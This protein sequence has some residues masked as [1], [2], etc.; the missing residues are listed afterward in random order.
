[1]IL[2][3]A[4]SHVPRASDQGWEAHEEDGKVH[5][6]Q[7]WE[8]PTKVH[9]LRS[10]LGLVN[11]YRRFIKGYS[12]RATPLTELLK[13]NK[14]WVWSPTFQEAFE[15]LKK[16]VCEEPVLSFP[17]H[18]K[19]YELHTDTPDFSIGGVLIQDG[20]PIAY[21]SRKLNDTKRRY[22][23]Q[24]KDMTAIFHYLRVWR[25]YL[26]GAKVLIL[27]HNVATSYFQTQK[28]LSPKQARWQDFLAEFDYILQ[29]KPV[30]ANVV[31]DALSRKVELAALSQVTSPLLDRIKEGL[32][33]EPL[34]KSI[35]AL[36]NEGKT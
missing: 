26:L 11:Y 1:M 35:I 16:V 7:E 28:K 4:R 5:A 32:H 10:F 24:E 23:V 18:T 21:E 19:P 29:Y 2:C 8:P 13:K 9:E 31:A 27:T 12:A 20:H 6:I 34:A 3:Q 30:K 17:D 33:Q 22:T 25:H 14:S 36:A 15:D